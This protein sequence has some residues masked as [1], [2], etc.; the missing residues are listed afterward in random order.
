MPGKDLTECKDLTELK[1]CGA[2]LGEDYPAV[3]DWHD[4]DHLFK[5]ELI[6]HLQAW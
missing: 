6:T 5:L 2:E 3:H 4:V 1:P